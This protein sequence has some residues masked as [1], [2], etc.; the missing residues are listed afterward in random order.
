MESDA[1]DIAGMTVKREDRTRI[2]GAD[3]IKFDIVTPGRSKISFIGR[4]AKPVY[5]G[6]RVLDGT[7][8]NT[9]E[10]FPEPNGMIIARYL[11]GQLWG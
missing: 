1:G 2:G 11:T 6:I 9:G 3:V 8:A 10:G 7:G 4:N 5:L